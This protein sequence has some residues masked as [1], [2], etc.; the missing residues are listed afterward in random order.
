MCIRGKIYLAI[1]VYDLQA[2]S[3][4]I[5]SSVRLIAVFCET[6][7]GSP[8]YFQVCGCVLTLAHRCLLWHNYYDTL[9]VEALAAILL[10]TRCTEL[11]G[12]N[13][14]ARWSF[15]RELRTYFKIYRILL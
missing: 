4:V 8:V 1:Q 11:N 10:L 13:M 2:N 3:P 15:F 9:S 6:G 7:E 5:N 14:V 12:W